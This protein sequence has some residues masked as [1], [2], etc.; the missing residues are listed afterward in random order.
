VRLN[1]LNRLKGR[2]WLNMLNTEICSLIAFF[3]LTSSLLFASASS[4]LFNYLN[5]LSGLNFR[6]VL[7]ISAV[8]TIGLGGLPLDE[9]IPVLMGGKPGCL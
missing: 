1:W 2:N 8:G 7:G 6:D 4:Q 3:A 5:N 9:G